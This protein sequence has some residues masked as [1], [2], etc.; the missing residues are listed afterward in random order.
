MAP[1]KEHRSGADSWDMKTSSDYNGD[2]INDM[3]WLGFWASRHTRRDVHSIHAGLQTKR[4]K[5]VQS[6]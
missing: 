5:K 2:G 4:G 3:L 6:S 1:L